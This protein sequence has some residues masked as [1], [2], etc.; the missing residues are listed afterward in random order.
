MHLD[1]TLTVTE[2]KKKPQNVL[3][4]VSTIIHWKKKI[5]FGTL[6]CIK[7]QLESEIISFYYM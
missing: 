3:K 1:W 5:G 2:K 4:E 6:P 7:I